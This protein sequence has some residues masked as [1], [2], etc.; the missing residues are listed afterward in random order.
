MVLVRY[1]NKQEPDITNYSN[2]YQIKLIDLSSFTYL[3]DIDEY[4]IKRDIYYPK[5]FT[6]SFVKE[7]L[8]LF[9]N[10]NKITKKIILQG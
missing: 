10:K 8:R 5:L 7:E 9:Y 1:I 4:G 2:C 6:E 3:N